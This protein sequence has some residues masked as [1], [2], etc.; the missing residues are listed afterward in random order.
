MSS[1]CRNSAPARR[2]TWVL[3]ALLLVA[4]AGCER[5]RREFHTAPAAGDPRPRLTE[6]QPGSPLPEDAVA[7]R[8]YERNA[9][10]I[11][12]GSHLFRQFNCVGCHGAGGGAIGPALM[13]DEWRYGG[14]IDQIHASILDGRP[15]GMPSWRGK[16]TDSQAWQLAA[17]VRS[18]SGNVPKS[19]SP[20]RQDSLTGPP[21]LN[22]LPRQPPEAPDPSAQRPAPR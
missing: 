10:H 15:N 8:E 12:Q 21:P 19:A 1:R 16:L 4:A 6:F 20:G 13:D 18:L 5:E 3:G 11:A 2:A 7:G 14:R 17:F 22:Q 9:Y